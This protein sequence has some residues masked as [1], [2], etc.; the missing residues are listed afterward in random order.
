MVKG[1]FSFLS[2]Y[3]I[4][5]QSKTQEMWLIFKVNSFSKITLNFMAPQNHLEWECLS[6]CLILNKQVW[7]TSLFHK[8]G[9]ANFDTNAHT[10]CYKHQNSVLLH[11]V[12]TPTLKQCTCFL[13]AAGKLSNIMINHVPYIGVSFSP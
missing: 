6:T 12:H 8:K 7:R 2:R 3:Y 1:I 11:Y 9:Q 5:N 10:E 13:R 4:A